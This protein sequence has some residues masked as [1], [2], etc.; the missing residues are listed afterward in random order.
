MHGAASMANLF[1]ENLQH[2]HGHN[3]ES[4]SGDEHPLLSVLVNKPLDFVLGV[5]A[6]HAP[7]PDG[8]VIDDKEEDAA[9]ARSA[10]ARARKLAASIAKKLPSGGDVVAGVISGFVCGLLM[11]VFCCVFAQ[12]IYGSHPSLAKG[13]DLGV[14]QHTLTALFAGV[15]TV[16][17]SKNRISIAGPDITPALFL[18]SA[19]GKIA[20]YIASMPASAKV[21]PDAALTT[22]FVMIA[23]T[24]FTIG[25][26]WIIAGFRR[27]TRAIEYM[28]KSVIAGF[29]ASVGYKVMLKAIDT[30]AGTH[31]SFAMLGTDPMHYEHFLEL[32]TWL[33]IAPA[34]PL[35]IVMYVLKREHW[36]NPIVYIPFLLLVPTLLFYVVVGGVYGVFDGTGSGHFGDDAA[37]A[38]SQA[39]ADGWFFPLF[40]QTKF[41]QLW[42]ALYGGFTVGDT[43]SSHVILAAIPGAAGDIIVCI[44]MAS[45]D[46]LGKQVGTKKLL[47]MQS[48]SLESE[49]VLA[50]LYNLPLAFLGGAPAYSQLKFNVLNYAIIHSKTSPIAGIVCAL[51]NGALFFVGY[52]VIN[53]FPRFLLGGLVFFAGMGFVVENLMDTLSGPMKFNW[54]DYL[55]VWLIVLV[56]VVSEMIYGVIFGVI[57]ALI[58]YMLG[59]ISCRAVSD[60]DI[61]EKHAL[62]RLSDIDGGWTK[63]IRPQVD[64]IKLRGLEDLVMIAKV[65]KFLFFGSLCELQIAISNWLDEREHRLPPCRRAKYLVLDLSDIDALD[66]RLA[67]KS[68]MEEIV[69]IVKQVS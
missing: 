10:S 60:R 32:K 22:V 12:I 30:S 53:F 17:K 27:V 45:I 7:S 16:A 18:A 11:F 20:L 50:G 37:Y 52:P 69:S 61:D 40:M 34:L 39:R 38:F 62:L 68:A 42:E 59:G 41:W 51:F 23:G 2:G 55:V 49:T 25:V 56:T 19:A 67:S 26:V 28:P 6:H 13:L 44:V 58:L 54:S 8:D 24:T 46:M 3:D 35:G 21:H 15:V 5:V 14:S 65:A 48:L 63:V 64:K 1:S 33:H 29:V 31:T 66:P 9:S 47:Q 36:S 57:I 43:F 4:D